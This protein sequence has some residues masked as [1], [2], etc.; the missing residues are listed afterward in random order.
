M[1]KTKLGISVGI[2]GAAVFFS[3]LISYIPVI[4]LAGYILLMEENEWLRK[5][6][7]KAVAISVAAALIPSLLGLLT[8]VFDFLNIILSWVR[9]NLQLGYPLRLNEL[10]N[11][12]VYF[13]RDGLMLICGFSALSLGTVKINFIDKIIDKHM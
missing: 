8:Y 13:L 2:L 10:I 6:A 3:G 4:I 12:A 11:N 9:I 5:A 1:Q 7:V